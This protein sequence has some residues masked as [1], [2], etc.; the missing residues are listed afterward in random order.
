MG[1]LLA[2]SA[3]RNISPSPELIEWIDSDDRYGYTGVADDLFCRVTVLS[4][5]KEHFV[6]IG[7][8]PSRFHVYRLAVLD[9]IAFAGVNG[10]PF[11]ETYEKMADA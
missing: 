4:N 11:S 3:I 10:I 7:S 5:G 8:D 9:G 6:I 1:K 2:G